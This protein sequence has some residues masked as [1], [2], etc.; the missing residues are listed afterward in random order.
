[1]K[2]GLYTDTNGDQMENE[3]YIVG[4]EEKCEKCDQLACSTYKQMIITAIVVEEGCEF[5]CGHRAILCGDCRLLFY[6]FL[7]AR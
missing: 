6:D 1:M 7:K 4:D 3:S 2:N 5:D